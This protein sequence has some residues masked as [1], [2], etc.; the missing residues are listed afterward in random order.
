MTGAKEYGHALF[1]LGEETGALERIAEDGR[2]VL[3]ALSENP[4]YI[5]LLDTPA[6]SALEKAELIEGAFGSL[7]KNLVN[8]LKLLTE[9]RLAHLIVGATKEFISEYELYSG[10]ER[11]EAVSAVPMTEEQI[12]SLKARLEE[13]TGKTVIV[14]NTV[15]P[16]ILGGIKLR[17]MGHQLDGSLK[18]RLDT[19]EN[20][21]QS[22][23]I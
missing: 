18:A 2:L 15:N 22:L 1:M 23:V 9:K 19:I 6:V 4:E 12:S 7:Q 13:L 8:F 10:I 14:K 16:S 11:A 21:L 20:N 17:Y 5:K 3:S